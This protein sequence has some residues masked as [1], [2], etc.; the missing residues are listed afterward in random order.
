MKTI[1]PILKVFILSIFTSALLSCSSSNDKKNTTA[2][3][4]T[5]Q[6]IQTN[7]QIDSLCWIDFIVGGPPLP[8]E[9]V[10]IDSLVK[11]YDLCYY[12]IENGCEVSDSIFEVQKKYEKQNQLYFTKLQSKLGMDWKK[13]F[14]QELL[15]L[16][17]KYIKNL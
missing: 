9:F 4:L 10:G 17:K 2:P 5:K 8:N 6:T 14:D 16:N 1:T 11:K 13:K 12:R 3:S 7:T 15:L